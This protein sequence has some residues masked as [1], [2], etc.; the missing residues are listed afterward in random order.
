M[1]HQPFWACRCFRSEFRRIILAFATWT[2]SVLVGGFFGCGIFIGFPAIGIMGSNCVGAI[3]LCTTGC[4][5]MGPDDVGLRLGIRDNSRMQRSFTA[6]KTPSG[7]I[8]RG[9]RRTA[10]TTARRRSRLRLSRLQSTIPSRVGIMLEGMTMRSLKA[11]LVAAFAAILLIGSPAAAN[12]ACNAGQ[13]MCRIQADT[14]IR[15]AADFSAKPRGSAG[16]S[17]RCS[18]LSGMALSKC[19]C[20]AKG[21]SGFPC[22]FRP[23]LRPACLCE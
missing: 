9:D 1:R 12:D 2:A 16:I 21:E 19:K 10:H 20:E 5:L 3:E 11:C 6:P 14:P 13:P 22:H 15:L 7:E 17:A 18:G 23:G 8:N 4:T